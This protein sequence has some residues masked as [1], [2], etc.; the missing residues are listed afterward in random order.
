MPH[1]FIQNQHSQRVAFENVTNSNHL[2]H[3]NDLRKCKE[4]CVVKK[5][6]SPLSVTKEGETSALFDDFEYT[7]EYVH[8]IYAYN[9]QIESNTNTRVK[10]YLSLRSHSITEKMRRILVDWL[11]QVQEEFQLLHE[12]L[13]KAVI[14]HDLFLTKSDRCIKMEE[15]QLVGACCLWIACKNEEIYPPPLNS[16]LALCDQIYSKQQFVLLERE[17]LHTTDFLISLPASYGLSR[18]LNKILDGDMAM[19][20]LSRYICE[21]SLLHYECSMLKPS[22]IA[23]AAIFIAA[24][25]CDKPWTTDVESFTG[26]KLINIRHEV[27]KLNSILCEAFNSQ[28]PS[29]I[30]SKYSHSI[31]FKVAE[32]EPIPL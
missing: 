9:C 1:V 30:T 22:K 19:L 29:H 14:L 28:N 5:V 3:G 12:T 4:P 8:D 7:P 10:D 18:L 13:Y 32:M 6:S 11:V 31:F 2:S 27:Q 15:Y 26:Y 17:I 23:T 25:M 21:L 16:F 24:C 20:T